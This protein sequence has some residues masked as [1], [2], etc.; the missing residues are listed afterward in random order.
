MTMIPEQVNVAIGDRI[1]HGGVLCEIT[2]ISANEL[3]AKSP[4]G[5]LHLVN[6]GDLNG[7]QFDY[8]V[9]FRKEKGD[10]FGKSRT[11]T[12]EKALKEE[13]LLQELNWKTKKVN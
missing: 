9:E 7:K 13:T 11:D 6:V 1:Y 10:L 12:Y 5:V 8:I 2:E 3:C 4:N